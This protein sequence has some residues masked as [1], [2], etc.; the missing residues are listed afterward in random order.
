MAW[1]R[2]KDEGGGRSGTSGR[3]RDKLGNTGGGSSTGR[4]G[5]KRGGR[6]YTADENLA[7]DQGT[8]TC[9]R[10]SGSGEVFAPK[11]ETDEDGG[12]A[13][14]DKITCPRCGG[15]GSVAKK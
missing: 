5:T 12:F 4:S 7:E 13:G 6:D 15:N 1:G 8:L 14:S 2:S 9:P 10:C 11:V 3:N